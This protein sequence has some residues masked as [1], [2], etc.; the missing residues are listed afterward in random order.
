[1]GVSR[2]VWQIAN[3]DEAASG[4]AAPG[5]DILQPAH[6]DDPTVGLNDEGAEG[7]GHTGS[8]MYDAAHTEACIDRTGCRQPHDRSP[9]SDVVCIASHA[10]GHERA[11]GQALDLRERIR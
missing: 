4:G 6:G 5:G 8:L 3:G 7:S 2:A 9:E 10:D 11:V 1:M